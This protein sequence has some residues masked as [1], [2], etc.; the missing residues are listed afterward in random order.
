M[1]QWTMAAAVESLRSGTRPSA[2]TPSP[3][4]I[5]TPAEARGGRSRND[6]A[7]SGRQHPDDDLG[8]D[9]DDV[10]DHLRSSAT[11]VTGR[12]HEVIRA[13]VLEGGP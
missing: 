7:G 8:K 5:E 10:A 4:P 2:D 9:D 3:F 6:G 1:Q 12:W 11:A 13:V